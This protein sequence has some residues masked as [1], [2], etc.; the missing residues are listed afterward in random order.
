MVHDDNHKKEA[1][2]IEILTS[3]V[4]SGILSKTFE[5]C[6]ADLSFHVGASNDNATR[7]GIQVKSALATK[8]NDRTWQFTCAKGYDG[9]LLICV[10]LKTNNQGNHVLANRSV[11]VIPGDDVKVNTVTWTIGRMS[12]KK[13]KWGAYSIDMNELDRRLCSMYHD[14]HIKKY[15]WDT[16]TKPTQS[17]RVIEFDNYNKRKAAF[18][19]LSYTDDPSGEHTQIDVIINGVPVQDK[20][21]FTHVQGRRL[22]VNCR[23]SM[24]SKKSRPYSLNDKFVALNVFHGEYI[25]VVSTAALFKA[26]VI[27]R[28]D[29]DT[30]GTVQFS[31]LPPL[32][33]T[34]S[35]SKYSSDMIQWFKLIPEN[36]Q[37]FLDS[38]LQ[39]EFKHEELKKAT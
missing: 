27:R 25:G 7:L 16:L 39:C 35:V 4:K 6:K 32:T 37:L 11:L 2:A 30:G 17:G 8:R 20:S 28:S 5:S 21:A 3:Y 14:E 23:K 38:L 33:T 18:D 1:T 15:N 13:D 26:G 10:P 36:T 19:A 24:G 29:G 34:S 31:V 22:K 12:E 9:L